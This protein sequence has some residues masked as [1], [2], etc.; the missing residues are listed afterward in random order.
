MAM[1]LTIGVRRAGEADFTLP[2]ALLGRYVDRTPFRM[3]FPAWFP[4]PGGAT[5]PLA[6][7][8]GLRSYGRKL[9]KEG[10]GFPWKPVLRT[11]QTFVDLE[12]VLAAKQPTLIYGLGSGVPHVVVPVQREPGGW[13]MLDP[14]YA[15][16]N[17]PIRW[18][19]SLLQKWWTNFSLLYP[20]GVMVTLE[21]TS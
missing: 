19:D 5:H 8:W 9:R 18:T 4:G 7:L 20:P 15:T 6:A 14:G 10:I 2:A 1:L 13:L 3:R 16:A 17:N 12:S 11:R 21:P